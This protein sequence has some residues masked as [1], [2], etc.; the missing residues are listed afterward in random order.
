MGRCT[1][2]E[3]L[4]EIRVPVIMIP[5]LPPRSLP[6]A[7]L[8]A[9]LGAAALLTD[10]AAAQTMGGGW[11]FGWRI[12]GPA[13]DDALGRSVAVIRD[14]D[15]DGLD[16]V[17]VGI[18]QADIG[19]KTNAGAVLV[20]SGLTG[21]VIRRH[22]GAAANDSFGEKVASAGDVDLDGF[23]D[24]LIGA[25]NSAAGGAA[26]T[27]SVYLFSGR[28]GA[29]LRRFDGGAYADQ[30]GRAISSCPDLDGDAVPD[31]LLGMP[32]SSPGGTSRA[33]S[34]RVFSGFTRGFLYQLNGVAVDDFFG[35]SVAGIGDL[36]GDG[37]GDF[38][39]G[40]EGVDA[41]GYTD[42]GAAY[43]FSGVGAGLIYS[44]VGID[45]D[46]NFGHAVT[47]LQSLDG[48]PI[49]DFAVGA[50]YADAGGIR[51]GE[52]T[53]VAGASGLPIRSHADVTGYLGTCVASAGDFDG[54]GY[55]DLVAGAPLAGYFGY[56]PGGVHVYSGRTGDLLLQLRGL[57][58][59]TSHAQWFGSDVASGNLNGDGLGDLVIGAE[60]EDVGLHTSAGRAYAF[61][62]FQ[63]YLTAD[64]RDVSSAAGAVVN[65]ALDF[66]LGDAGKQ[67]QLLAS[68]AGTG[69]SQF[70]GLEIPLTKGDP[71]WRKMLSTTPPTGFSAVSGVL[72][73][74]GD[75]S[76][77]LTVPAGA[78]A[79]LVGSTIH[80]A[81]VSYNL[82]SLGL[83]SSAAVPLEFVP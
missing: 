18:Y 32:S 73:A 5:M 78:A 41:G 56:A 80:F 58:T 67:F 26:Y 22:N 20:L 60:G 16:D 63:P 45:D 2:P 23:G 27:G 10:S 48:D 61:A 57:G 71:A 44:L 54:D 34:V 83:R 46:D 52:V 62:G 74:A 38:I 9:L 31:I 6:L 50:P 81:A 3:P 37:L 72:D 4:D 68:G 43:V 21:A 75:A 19:P 36:D 13:A 42:V 49:P 51:A 29:L 15:G 69:P 55:G 47:G 7:S 8:V 35:T 82:P 40:A 70:L 53:V 17:L 79:S 30:L 28:L 1:H 24:Y 11:E 76:V 77:S 39:V 33:G 25:P 64:T 59:S 66:P 12:P 14:V 65:F